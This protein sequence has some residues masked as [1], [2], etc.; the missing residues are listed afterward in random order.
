MLQDLL[1]NVENLRARV[2]QPMVIV[3]GAVEIVLVVGAHA[4]VASVRGAVEA[5]SV[6]AKVLGTFT[7][8]FV[9][10]V[11]AVHGGVG[12]VVA[13]DL[14]G[15]KVSHRRATRRFKRENA[16]ARVGESVKSCGLVMEDGQ[17][18]R[19]FIGKINDLPRDKQID[20]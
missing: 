14:V 13:I 11:G 15:Q 12:H 7:L 18:S 2:G 6:V 9:N 5:L 17:M 8:A 20:A 4:A 16:R 1:V 3:E 19:P 10:T